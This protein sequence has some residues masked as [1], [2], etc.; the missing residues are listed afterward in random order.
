MLEFTSNPISFAC[1][2]ILALFIS[3]T[4]YKSFTSKSY[5]EFWSPLTF[6]C[7][8]YLYY[9]IVNPINFALQGRVD[10]LGLNLISAADSAWLGAFLSFF[11]LWFGFRIYHKKISKTSL[12]NFQLPSSK[13]PKAGLIL[14]GLGL[15]FWVYTRG[16]QLNV[17]AV[18][19]D[20][21]FVTGGLS[22]YFVNG[23]SF[24][25]AAV[26]FLFLNYLK[27]RNTKYFLW[28]IIPLLLVIITYLTQGSRFRLVYL[29]IALATVFYLYRK[30]R[31]NPILWL[32]F[33]IGFYLLMGVIEVTRNYSR[34]LDLTKLEQYSVEDISN[35]ASN[36]SRVFFFSGEVINTVS[37]TNSYIYFEP[38]YTAILMPIPR[39]FFPWKPDAE[40]L[41]DI[42]LQI[43][44]TD[45][46]GAA[47]LNY[48]EYYY[49]FGWFGILFFSFIMGVLLKYF[50]CN[51]LQ[52]K[53]NLLAIVSLG[54]INGL[55]YVLISRGYMAQQFFS[56]MY[57]IVIPLWL[58]KKMK[59]KIT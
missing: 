48:A 47:F 17:F 8:V 39:V 35:N 38:V 34:G 37:D 30:R 59:I 11:S 49:A 7:L 31:P 41:N 46:T 16:F 45:A 28:F 51:Y 29:V 10:F 5:Y 36:E 6:V 3:I 24:F 33:G 9:V 22:M 25:I 26:S 2:C 27:R 54:L 56:Y 50:W 13:L 58:A 18:D 14:F 55:V 1:V 19:N 53:E 4:L 15:A 52:N 42:Q 12:F 40:Y 23:I 43:L 21:E 32:G 20:R 44:G 57:F